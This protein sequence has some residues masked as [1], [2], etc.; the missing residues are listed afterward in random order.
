[1]KTS[2]TTN[3]DDL[4]ANTKSL[5]REVLEKADENHG[6]YFTVTI[7]TPKRK[8]SEEQNR[9]FHALLNEFWIS[10]C[11]SF[12]TYEQMRDHYKLRAAGAKEYMFADPAGQMTVKTLSEVRGWY[13]EV[14]YS[15]A[16][17]TKD[18]RRIA[19]DLIIDEMYESGVNTKKFDE[20]ME[21]LYG[22]KLHDTGR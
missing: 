14:P 11:S 5:A 9:A 21:G 2:F 20:I 8:G 17:M 4:V 3:L 13:V 18:Q 12:N 19:I 1:M 10:G 7:E 22:Y 6:G 15:W 16:E